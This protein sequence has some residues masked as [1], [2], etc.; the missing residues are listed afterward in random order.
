MKDIYLHGII[1]FFYKDIAPLVLD[2]VFVMIV[3]YKD[4]APTELGYPI[5]IILSA[6]KIP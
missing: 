4:I 6:N 1:D 2:C 5:N 3:F